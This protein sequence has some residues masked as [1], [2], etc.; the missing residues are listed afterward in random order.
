MAVQ[1]K[2]EF[3]WHKC[4]HSRHLGDQAFQS[5]SLDSVGALY[6]LRLLAGQTNNNGGMALGNVRRMK[7][8]DVVEYISTLL[9]GEERRRSLAKSR[10]IF[11]ELLRAG[12][13]SVSKVGY[14]TITGWTDEQSE[15]RTQW[16]DYKRSQ[17]QKSNKDGGSQGSAPPPPASP[18]R[19]SGSGS[20]RASPR[21]SG[22]DMSNR[23]I[24]HVQQEPENLRTERFI[25]PRPE[26]EPEPEVTVE[27][28]GS[29]IRDAGEAGGGGLDVWTGD[30]IAMAMQLTCERGD[31]PRNV[32]KKRLRELQAEFGE[33]TG[34]SLFRESMNA[35]KVF[36]QEGRPV[37]SRTRFL[38]G[39]INKRLN[40]EAP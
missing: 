35:L 19:V 1:C 2:G 28:C 31:Y 20:G 13:L 34:L 15:G 40:G 11:D 9:V 10:R 36:L 23:G 21:D 24:G 17:R 12:V 18:A 26:P 8:A 33:Q 27:T 38:N 25:S 22:L 30:P 5:L 29:G 32:W 3:R 6:R 4:S 16:A 14:V 39:A 37:R 7:K